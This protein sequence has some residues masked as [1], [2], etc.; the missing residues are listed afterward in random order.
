MS[1]REPE[2]LWREYR[3]SASE[4]AFRAVVEHYAKLVYS[5]ALRRAGHGNQLVED[6]TQTVFTDL[7]RKPK[8]LPEDVVLGGWLYR[9]ACFVAANFLR[10][11]QRRRARELEAMRMSLAHDTA[12]WDV[13]AEVLD[14]SMH[15]L[16]AA[17][18]DVLVLR[19]FEERDL[20]SVGRALG[21]SEDA[22]QKRVSRAL[23]KLREVLV[24]RGLALSIGT[25]ATLLAANAV[26]A[27]PM[28]VV[29]AIVRKGMAAT[30][31]VSISSLLLTPALKIAAL[32]LIAGVAITIA[33]RALD[34]KRVGV[35]TEGS[36]AKM[37]ARSAG[38]LTPDAASREV[39]GGSLSKDTTH[40]SNLLRV[41][42]LAVESGRPIP[43]AALE[44]VC[45]GARSTDYIHLRAQRTGVC[46]IP[47]PPDLEKLTLYSREEGF[48]DTRV[49]WS[50]RLLE[51]IPT[52]YILRLS[53]ATPI[54]G[55]VVGPQGEPI[56]GAEVGFHDDSEPDE[57]HESGESHRFS[58]IQTTSGSNGIW[59]IDRIASE[60]IPLLHGS[61][62]HTNYGAEHLV[63][64]RHDRQAEQELRGL[65][66]VFRLG[67]GAL[68]RGRVVDHAGG[69]ISSAA[70]LIGENGMSG[71]RETRTTE[72]GTFAVSGCQFG[73][74]F[75][76]AHAMGFAGQTIPFEIT[77]NTA[78]V[79]IVL[80]AGRNLKLRVVDERGAPVAKAQVINESARKTAQVDFS[81][82]TDAA[83]E[84]VWSNAPM[85]NLFL[86]VYAERLG[87]ADLHD[88]QIDAVETEHTFAF[89]RALVVFGTV[90]DDES[91]ERIPRFSVTAGHPKNTVDGDWIPF[92]TSMR[93]FT[94][95]YAGGEYRRVLNESVHRDGENAFVFRF[96]A[97]GFAPF[98]S[99]R[100]AAS[101][102]QTR[103]DVRLRRARWEEI[104]VLKPDGSPAA[105]AEIGTV[106]RGARLLFTPP[107]LR[108][109]TGREGTRRV[110][111]NG[112]IRLLINDDSSEDLVC[113][114]ESGYAEVK[115][116]ALAGSAQIQL[117]AW[118][119]IDGSYFRHGKPMA[120][121]LLTLKHLRTDP[122]ALA[123][124]YDYQS[125][126]DAA[127]HFVIEKAPPGRWGF[128]EI[129]VSKQSNGS[130]SRGLQ[131]LGEIE[132]RSGE[133][134][135]NN[136][137][138]VVC[139]I[140]T[141][142]TLPG[143]GTLHKDHRL[144]VTLHTPMPEAPL[145]IL[146]DEAEFS[147]WSRALER[148]SVLAAAR[149]YM[150][151]QQ[152]DGT[153]LAEDVP[154]GS[155]TLLA[156]LTEYD[157]AKKRFKLLSITRRYGI[158]LNDDASNATVDL[159]EIA[160]QWLPPR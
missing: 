2:E 9:H 135:T 25:L 5:V 39:A 149:H 13:I 101:E 102:G 114:H 75:L 93:R 88:E 80:G 159:G 68:V 24:G 99:R 67:E 108:A 83:G 23:E 59:R 156:R 90:L 92:W 54:G 132:V 122:Q 85:T 20:R 137:G 150:F 79:E 3:R 160:L 95:Q 66:Y 76:T 70:V 16:T 142:V 131:M 111:A 98:V 118:G 48:A 60:M 49:A 100:I 6:I 4:E 128:A 94:V 152:P 33:W 105:F 133:T 71:S 74:S 153:F 73:H 47:V 110:S 112:T 27:V 121:A 51:T 127:G 34:E 8:S 119:R 141:R 64:V 77:T 157:P 7:A 154:P 31:A 46:E 97:E 14:E 104:T 61:A 116:S 145:E 41:T 87:F 18:R 120:G 123:F 81:G 56:E 78:P 53:R 10:H 28:H 52:N 50:P 44:V 117:A 84:L 113:V 134:V 103:L 26:T 136:I 86:S 106:T 82:Y 96:Q 62:K 58:W 42:V 17:D 138:T 146:R 89:R 155:Y 107:T 72:D 36:S 21:I 147:K 38:A 158:E 140:A 63:P 35:G 37:P 144:F 65:R 19:F 139:R 11:E 57:P 151:N 125:R 55:R 69:G 22:A 143:D 109:E 32:L 29:D 126:A 148:Q 129:K 12:N 30:A 15:A 124:G 91:G 45:R 43:N 1:T 130:L 115:R 40:S